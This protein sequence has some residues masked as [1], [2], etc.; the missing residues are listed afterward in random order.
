MKKI[1][2]LVLA[3]MMVFALVACG[4]S[5]TTSKDESK[6]TVEASS[7]TQGADDD[8][9]DF[10]DLENT[11]SEEEKTLDLKETE[12][13]YVVVALKRENIKINSVDDFAD[14]TCAYIGG[15]DSEVWA[16]Y[17]D[18]KETGLYNM[19][20]DLHSGLSG[21]NFDLGIV[22]DIGAKGYDDWEIV[23]ELKAE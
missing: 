7:I 22:S 19:T 9:I 13:K 20:N 2:A 21:S 18:F 17:Y 23:W 3:I 5:E 1:L 16:D 12:L 6:V 15:C 14:Y 8:V 10:E 11:S 4:T